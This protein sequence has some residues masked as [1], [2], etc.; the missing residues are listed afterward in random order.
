MNLYEY[1][2]KE[3][4]AKYDIPTPRGKVVDGR[5]DLQK[6][7]E[8]IGK[9]KFG[10]VKSQVLTGGRGKAGGIKAVDTLDQGLDAMQGLIGMK[11][12]GFPVERV[13]V[14]ERLK[15]KNEYFISI[16]LDPEESLPVLLISPKGGMDIEEV[17]GEYPEAIG[18]YAIKLQAD[19]PSFAMIELVKNLGFQR[20][21]WGDLIN[22]TSKLYR[23][24]C[25][26]EATLI[27]I[28][29]LIETVDGKLIAADG[30]LNVDDNALFRQPDVSEYK[31]EF[32]DMVLK[33]K[34]VDYVD[35]DSGEVGV[36]CVGAGMTM[37]T[38]DLVAHLG[39][40]A[41]CFLDMSHGVNPAGFKAALD[42]LAS[43]PDIKYVLVN[44]FGGLTRMDEIAKSILEA[45]D[46]FDGKFTKPMVLRLQGTNAD[47]GQ[48]IMREAGYQVC[49]ELEDLLDRFKEMLREEK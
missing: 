4:F 34:G 36:L 48:E 39:S 14:E 13:L 18:E 20:Q 23:A 32:K 40:K 46:K 1:Q 38:M 3:I 33:G 44:M 30:R 6:A 15:I 12:K 37:L 27:E 17:A 47:K 43:E 28:N 35:L 21:L 42:L 7:F 16:T 49:S 8:I 5:S 29:P 45:I 31:Q 9:D 26:K 19:L 41:R 11:I 24:F 10:M 22:I 25:E 2:A